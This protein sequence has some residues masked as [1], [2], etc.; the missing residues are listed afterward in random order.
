MRC[1]VMPRFS[2]NPSRT[3]RFGEF[4]AR[5][6]AEQLALFSTGEEVHVGAAQIRLA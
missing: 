6:H 4:T 1:H 2:A 5:A 3:E